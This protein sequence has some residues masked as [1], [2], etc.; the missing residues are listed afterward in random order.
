MEAGP[1]PGEDV[2]FVGALRVSAFEDVGR[3]KAR[4]DAAVR[5][6]HACRRAPGFDRVYA[7]G[8]REALNQEAHAREGIPLNAVTRADL[9]EV[10]GSL[11]VPVPAWQT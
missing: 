8:E 3:F 1:R 2:H 7:P 11:G 9:R 4:V 10:A 6:L 5:Q